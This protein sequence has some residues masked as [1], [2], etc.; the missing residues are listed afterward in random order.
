M[1]AALQ[2]A[3]LWRILGWLLTGAVMILSLLPSLPP[4]PGPLAWDK[5]QHLLAYAVLML[6]FRQAYP[7]HWRWPLL[8]LVL[9]TGLEGLQGLSVH[10]QLEAYDMLA[11][12]LGV[13]LGLALAAFTPLERLLQ[14]LDRGLAALRRAYS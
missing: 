1:T 14:R 12:A 11:N 4:P 7:P 9:G 10:R 5:A 6:W 13:G 8:L 3:R 2:H